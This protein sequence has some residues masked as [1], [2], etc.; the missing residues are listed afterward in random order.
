[1]TRSSRPTRSRLLVR[2]R[3]AFFAT[4]EGAGALFGRRGPAQKASSSSTLRPVRAQS[5]DTVISPTNASSTSIPISRMLRRAGPRVERPPPRTAA[6]RVFFVQRTPYVVDSKGMNLATFARRTARKPRFPGARGIVRRHGKDATL[7]YARGDTARGEL[8][9]ESGELK[10]RS[11]CC[12]S[13]CHSAGA[14]P[15][16]Q[17][18]AKN[19]PDSCRGLS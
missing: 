5:S 9:V 15:V 6:G 1:M 19:C 3:G 2:L 16:H 10:W 8:V 13:R 12:G 11:G 14:P 4:L 17:G 7:A 18:A